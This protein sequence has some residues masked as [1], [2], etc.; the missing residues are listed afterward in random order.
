MAANDF[1]D[2]LL[3]SFGKTADK[4]VK[5]TDEFVSVQKVKNK[6]SSL[7]SKVSATYRNIGKQI[8]QEYKKGGAVSGE[9]AAYCA[10]IEELQKEI[11]ACNEEIAD[12]KGEVICRVCGS[13]I[14]A[15]A[16][17]CSKCGSPRQDRDDAVDAEFTEV[18]PDEEEETVEES[19][20]PEEAAEEGPAP[21]T[22]EA[23]VP[24]EEAAAETAEDEVETVEAEVIEEE[25]EAET[26]MEAEETEEK[27]E[28]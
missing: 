8:Y 20:A 9:I 15:D 3:N 18:E 6:K 26:G 27:T 14:P 2:N 16:E 12:L 13:P 28:E 22:A 24:E 21:E 4:V 1:F 10:R 17:F 25:P 11:D 5:K 7:E 23:E 19:E